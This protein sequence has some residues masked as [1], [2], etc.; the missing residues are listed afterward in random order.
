[1][2]AARDLAFVGITLA[3]WQLDAMVRGGDGLV[4]LAIGVTA[5]VLATVAGYLAHEWGH[6]TAALASG[7]VVHLPE[8][9]ASVFL[10][11]YDV[12][13]NGRR[14][15]LLMSCGGFIASTLVIALFFLVL[16]LDTLA[17]RVTLVLTLL[18]VAAT[19]ILEI[20]PAW[21][22]YRGGPMPTGVAYRSS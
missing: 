1:M 14:Q 19:F 10:F 16:P 7:S 20:P 12:T 13:R 17:G 9:I 5:G 3:V 22:V 6:L 18:G 8:R 2:L 4:P 11:N 15:F 21:R